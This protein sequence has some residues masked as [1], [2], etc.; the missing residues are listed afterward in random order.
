MSG[1]RFEYK[2]FVLEDIARQ[3]EHIRKY[4]SDDMSEETK[5]VMRHAE[6]ILDTAQ[7]YV[8]RIDWLVSG[9]EDEED[10]HRLLSEGTE[11][12]L[13]K[14]YLG[15]DSSLEMPPSRPPETRATCDC[16]GAVV[17]EYTL[18]HTDTLACVALCDD[19]E[20]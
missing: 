8:Q 5:K 2:Q 9:D 11:R 15:R 13:A 17:D 3:I 14:H 1:G 10:L 6:L 4:E 19:C 20:E 18:V 7:E 16:C 12:I